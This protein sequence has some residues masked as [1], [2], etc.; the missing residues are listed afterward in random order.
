MRISAVALSSQTTDM[1]TYLPTKM[2]ALGRNMPCAFFPEG[3][4]CKRSPRRGRLLSSLGG[5]TV[6]LRGYVYLLCKCGMFFVMSRK[7]D[8]AG[9]DKMAVR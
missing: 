6:I 8:R 3:A 9:M 5:T 4:S 1:A 2:H 7:S